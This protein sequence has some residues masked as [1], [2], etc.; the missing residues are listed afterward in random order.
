MVLRREQDRG[1]M[2][3]SQAHAQ[4]ALLAFFSALG[5]KRYIETSQYYGGSY[6]VLCSWN[7][8]VDPNDLPGLWR[9]ACEQ[10]SLQCTGR[11]EV[12][13]T[14]QI[15]PAEVRF[16]VRFRLDSGDL[17]VR[18]PCCGATTAEIP[19]RSEFAFAVRRTGGRYLVMDL[20]PHVP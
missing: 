4:D 3:S 9:S 12:L 18:G 1:T 11:A 5:E 17:F 2:H 7:P 16:I 8:G 10:N 6:E 15:S 20:P 19:P 13:R 14:E